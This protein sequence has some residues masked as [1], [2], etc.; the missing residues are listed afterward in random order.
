MKHES[1]ARSKA[2]THD[3]PVALS[4]RKGIKSI[5]ERCRSAFV[6]ICQHE[7]SRRVHLGP[8]RTRDDEC[9][10]CSSTESLL[11]SLSRVAS[12]ICL[13]VHACCYRYALRLKTSLFP[14]LF[15][16]LFFF[17]FFLFPF[18]NRDKPARLSFKRVFR[19]AQDKNGN[20]RVRVSHSCRQ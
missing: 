8:M 15:S 7:Q 18:Y 19:A 20:G 3:G 1:S 9:A 6:D 4:A 2:S 11:A 5:S 10:R 17:P 13:P 14:L 16:S 12:R